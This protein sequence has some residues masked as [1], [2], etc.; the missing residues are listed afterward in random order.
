M[1]AVTQYIR[2]IFLWSVVVSH[3]TGPLPVLTV[4]RSGGGAFVGDGHARAS[5]IAAAPESHDS[6]S[7]GCTT[8]TVKVMY[9]WWMPQNS[10]QTPW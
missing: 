4:E 10:E 5:P 1:N 8:R 6:N 2:P 3:A 9:A 7:S